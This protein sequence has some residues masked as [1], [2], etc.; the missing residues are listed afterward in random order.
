MYELKKIVKAVTSKFVETGASFYKKSICRA[1]V[2]P[3][4]RNTVLNNMLPHILSPEP[5][6][7]YSSVFEVILTVHRR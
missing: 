7:Y 4:L 3:R 1:A 5:C 6:T 2:S